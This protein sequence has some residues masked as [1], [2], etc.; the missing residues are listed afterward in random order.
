MTLKNLPGG[1]YDVTVVLVDANGRRTSDHRE[2]MV[3]SVLG[4]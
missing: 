1:Q 4:D 2:V 3:T